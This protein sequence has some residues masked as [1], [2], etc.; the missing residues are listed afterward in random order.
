MNE[1]AYKGY[2][3]CRE[4]TNNWQAIREAYGGQGL[5]FSIA[6]HGLGGMH[7]LIASADL[8]NQNIDYYSHNY[9]TPRT[10]NQAGANWYNSNF[11]GEAGERGIYGNDNYTEFIPVGPNYVHTGTP[12]Y[13]SG[14]D[15]QTLG[16]NL[17]ICWDGNSQ[18]GPIVDDPAC[19][20]VPQPNTT[21]E[22]DHYYYFSNVGTCGGDDLINTTIVDA[23]LN[24]PAMLW[25]ASAVVSSSPSTSAGAAGASGSTTK[26]GAAMGLRLEIGVAGL[27][28]VGAVM[29]V[30]A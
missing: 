26:K 12:F 6:G 1:F 21:A 3:E 19:L 10:F 24:S 27:A 16:P 23:F 20:P 4:E 30:F 25:N 15:G 17:V 5:V 28:L 7:S 18:N 29:V 13:Y 14:L 22:Q 2:A 11:N 8:H 9:G